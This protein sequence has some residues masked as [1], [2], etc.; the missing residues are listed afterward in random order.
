MSVQA[1]FLGVVLIWATTPLA[2]KWSSAGAGFLFGVASRMV[3]G[4]LVCL[5]L[6]ALLGRRLPRS[7]DALLTYL[8]AGLGLWAA[9]TSVYWSAQ[10][11]ASGLI[12]VLFGLSPV[13]TG[14]M[15]ALWL[16][17]RALTPVRLAG[18]GL[19]LAGLSLV[20]AQALVTSTGMGLGVAGVLFSVLI[21]CA[22]AVWIKRI[23]AGIPALETTTGALL[24]ALPLFVLNWAVQDGELP[25]Q[26][27]LRTA[28]S[29][30]YLAVFGSALGFI[31]YYYVLQRVEA[32]RVALITLMTPVM[33]LFLGSYL[34]GEVIGPR[35]LVG[36]AAILAGLACF[37]WG[38]RWL[39]RPT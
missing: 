34:N 15:A 36:T 5:T 3:L 18:M 11:I 27:D 28:G 14:V 9:M 20:F 38:E 1:A 23:G 12:S 37:Q 21:H 16:G 24:V 17:E 2:I 25:A 10:F 30:V 6:V 32:S 19:G 39:A 26:L 35:E 8:A 29:I 7:R 22:S 33:A 31:L 13:V 4:M